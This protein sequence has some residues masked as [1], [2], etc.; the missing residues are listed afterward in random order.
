M[1]LRPTEEDEN[2]GR[3]LVVSHPSHE[4]APCEGWGTP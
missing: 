2:E 3:T 4:T 1:G